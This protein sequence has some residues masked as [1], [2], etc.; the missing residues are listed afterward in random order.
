MEQKVRL[1]L[2]VVLDPDV[3]IAI[4]R[5]L[6][7]VPADQIGLNNIVSLENAIQAAV[8]Q[9]IENEELK[10]SINKDA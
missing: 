8:N 9:Q 5:F 2:K 4:R 10:K 7:S 1:Q 3:A 6:G